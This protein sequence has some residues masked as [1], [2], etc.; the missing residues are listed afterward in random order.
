MPVSGPGPGGRRVLA[1]TGAGPERR[2]DHRVRSA[3][4]AGTARPGRRIRT[5]GCLRERLA[6]PCRPARTRTPRG[7]P[8]SAARGEVGVR[9]VG[10]ERRAPRTWAAAASA[11]QG[12]EG[13]T[14]QEG[15]RRR[16]GE[17]RL[18]ARSVGRRRGGSEPGGAGGGR[19]A[20]GGVSPPEVCPCSCRAR[21]LPALTSAPAVRTSRP[22]VSA[23]SGPG[24]AA[25]AGLP[26]RQSPAAA[27]L[28][29]SASCPGAAPQPEP[30]PAS[31]ARPRAKSSE[32]SRPNRGPGPPA[33]EGGAWPASTPPH[34]IIPHPGPRAHTRSCACMS[35]TPRPQGLTFHTDTDTHVHTRTYTS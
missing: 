12:P 21:P 17:A 7:A 30:S 3:P 20:R 29:L 18:W 32:R 28:L 16:A 35:C 1:V 15:E 9:G 23:H 31:P 26:Y 24:S 4:G 2:R 8:Q 25:C 11:G 33:A 22:A 5:P 10:T 34:P 27:A 13:R 6:T 14:A 19:G